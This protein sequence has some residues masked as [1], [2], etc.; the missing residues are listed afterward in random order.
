MIKVPDKILY[1]TVE[2]S[3]L[4]RNNQCT[5]S[6]TERILDILTSEF[7]QQHEDLEYETLDDY[8]AGHKTCHVDNQ[9]VQ[10]LNIAFRLKRE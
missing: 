9:V 4:L 10:S 2:I 1:L 7:K 5:Y 3:Q 6:E 8:F